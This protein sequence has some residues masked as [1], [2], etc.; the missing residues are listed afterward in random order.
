MSEKDLDER[1]FVY[2]VHRVQCRES[3]CLFEILQVLRVALCKSDVTSESQSS[4]QRFSLS[5][6]FVKVVYCALCVF[7][8]EE[9]ALLSPQDL[10]RNRNQI[11]DDYCDITEPEYAVVD[12]HE[13][14]RN[15]CIHPARPIS[16]EK[17]Y[18]GREEKAHL[19]FH[20]YRWV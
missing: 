8:Y 17:E 16:E 20:S 4:R 1:H 5:C 12:D 6:R 11:C 13:E 18:A 2:W 9:A 3:L 7:Q 19:V 14:E 15:V 10:G